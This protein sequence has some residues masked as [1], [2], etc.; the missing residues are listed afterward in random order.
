M[1]S[2]RS[3]KLVPALHSNTV[4]LKRKHLSNNHC[5]QASEPNYAKC[6]LPSKPTMTCLTLQ[7]WL[8]AYLE[9]KWLGKLQ[10]GEDV[11]IH[12]GGSGV[13]TAAI[14]LA[15]ALGARVFVTAGSDEK[16]Q[17]AKV[18][19]EL[20]VQQ[21]S[22]N[23]S[24][25]DILSRLFDVRWLYLRHKPVLQAMTFSEDY[26]NTLLSCW[27]VALKLFNTARVWSKMCIGQISYR[28]LGF[29]SNVSKYKL[30]AVSGFK[31]SAD[32]YASL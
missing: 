31:L 30:Q 14:Q 13:G 28:K 22:W 29:F 11:L 9:L 12:A 17:L 7:V 27:S 5:L 1:S 25:T 2:S 18:S 23:M 32:K 6:Y 8:T 4:A 10:E 16:C 15:K 20:R 21:D 3:A 24:Y 26:S 19:W